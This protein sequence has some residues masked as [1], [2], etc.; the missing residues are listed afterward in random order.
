MHF[1]KKVALPI[2]RNYSTMAEK[3]SDNIQ[4]QK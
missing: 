1:S 2:S 3:R 4:R